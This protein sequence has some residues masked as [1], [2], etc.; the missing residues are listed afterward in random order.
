MIEQN[1]SKKQYNTR[2]VTGS[3]KMEEMV[4]AE[5]VILKSVQYWNFIEEIQ[6]VGS[7]KESDCMFQSRQNAHTRNERLKPSSSLF[8][9]N[10]LSPTGK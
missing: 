5:E 1:G 2:P 7:L 8:R 6:S 4:L 10:P 3:P 9:L